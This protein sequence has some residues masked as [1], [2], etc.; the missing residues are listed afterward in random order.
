MGAPYAE[1]KLGVGATLLDD[2]VERYRVR[3]MEATRR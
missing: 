1:V 3:P 2:A